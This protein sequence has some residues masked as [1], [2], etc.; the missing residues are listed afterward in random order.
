[1]STLCVTAVVAEEASAAPAEQQDAGADDRRL[2]GT[3][4]PQDSRHT[5]R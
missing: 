3:L 5:A 2:A 1:M 4:L